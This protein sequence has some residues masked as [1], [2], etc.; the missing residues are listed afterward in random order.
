MRRI[1][2][3][4]CGTYNENVD[5]CTN[6][7]TL[8]NFKKR[9]EIEFKKSEKKRAHNEQQ[10]QENS[11]KWIEKYKNHRFLLVRV[12]AYIIY[13]IWAA[14]MAIGTFIAWLFTIIAA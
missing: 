1:K 12:F 13:S 11:L 8:I 6:C 7:N 10:D 14:V 4:N 5:Y 3:P 9:R 2:C